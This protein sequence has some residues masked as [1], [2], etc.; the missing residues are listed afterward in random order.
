MIKN[1]RH[2]GLKALVENGSTRGIEAALAKR[3]IL[4]LRVLE[5]SIEPA[6]MDVSGWNLHPLKGSR[7]GTWAVKVTAN[8][9][10]TFGFDGEDAVDVNLEDYQK[11]AKTIQTGINKMISE[12]KMQGADHE[13][14]HHWL[15]PLMEMNKKLA[16]VASADE[17]KELFGAIR[18][19]IGKYGYYFE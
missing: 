4:R 13:A 8:W 18:K 16:D 15:E 12:C 17:G 11:T 5:D 14:L 1:F 19:Q 9:R 3:L 6:D 2:K 10:L 7:A